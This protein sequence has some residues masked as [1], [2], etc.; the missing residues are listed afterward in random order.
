MRL[1]WKINT[2][3]KNAYL[4]IIRDTPMGYLDGNPHGVHSNYQIYTAHIRN[5][6]KGDVK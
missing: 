1:N 5:K 4:L 2:K 6:I 3:L